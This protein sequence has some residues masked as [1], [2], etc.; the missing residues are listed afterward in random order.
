MLQLLHS[1]Y[2]LQKNVRSIA[3]FISRKLESVQAALHM[4]A[5][6]PW[7][8]VITAGPPASEGD[9]T[10]DQVLLTL[11]KTLGKMGLGTG[12]RQGPWSTIHSSL[13]QSGRLPEEAYSSSQ[14]FHI[15]SSLCL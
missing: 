4:V 11:Y 1:E 9:P 12:S 3:E 13:G 14:C 6:V 10:S 15:Y 2:K 5:A 8:H 7:D